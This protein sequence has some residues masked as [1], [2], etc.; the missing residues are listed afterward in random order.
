MAGRSSAEIPASQLNAYVKGLND[1]SQKKLIKTGARR[2]KIRPDFVGHWFDVFNG[3]SYVR[4]QVTEEMLGKTLGEVAGRGITAQLRHVSI[5]SRKMRRVLAML[6]DRPSLEEAVNRMNFTPKVAALHVAQTLKAAAANYLAKPGAPAVRPE[7]LKIT[8]LYS[9]QGPS[10]KRIRYQSMGRVFRYKKRYSHLIVG[11]EPT[12]DAL[13]AVAERSR[14]AKASGRKGKA[15]A[16]ESAAAAEAA[17]ET[18]K[19][20]TKKKSA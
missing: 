13:Q 11:V 2:A 5:P 9:E 6:E 12:A 8:K 17:P 20:S 18:K 3:T 14:A 15:A 19:K 4:V 16:V 7:E 1:A 10:A